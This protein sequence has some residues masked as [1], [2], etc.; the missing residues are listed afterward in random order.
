[1]LK[2]KGLLSGIQCEPDIA[3]WKW[4]DMILF[5]RCSPKPCSPILCTGVVWSE[6]LS[7]RSHHQ[8]SEAEMEQIFHLLGESRN[9]VRK[10]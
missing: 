2:H 7:A 10:S 8:R 6:I 9:W 5:A 3:T 1:M 4:E